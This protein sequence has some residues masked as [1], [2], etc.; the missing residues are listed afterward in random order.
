MFWN[1]Y[2]EQLNR[3]ERML[4]N[5]HNHVVVQQKEING[6]A[7]DLQALTE[8]VTRLET[9]EAG[10]VT[11]IHSLADEVASLKNDPVALQALVDR[12]KAAD[13]TLSAALVENTPLAPVV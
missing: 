1:N 10:A 4:V 7:L 11:L 3:I 5:I 8:E 6:M 9:I 2:T 12:I 13:D